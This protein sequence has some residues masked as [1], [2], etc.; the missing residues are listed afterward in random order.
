MHIRDRIR[1]L[2][3]VRASD[4]VPNPKNWRTHPENQKNVLRGVLSEIGYADALIARELDDGRLMLIDGHLRA[5]TTPEQEVPVLVLD[6]DEDD[7]DKLLALLDPLSG[8][9]GK[10]EELLA[11]LVSEV[12]TENKAISDL[13]YEIVEKDKMDTVEIPARDEI[14]IPEVYQIVIS[15]DNETSQE[16][17]F[18]E[19]KSR[20]FDCRIMNL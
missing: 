13:L 2:R 16:K 1:E 9:A 15:C 4:L 12:E 14:A 6:I 18:E 10:D 20:G 19:L 5:E 8:M 17:L 3:R 7:S 11:A